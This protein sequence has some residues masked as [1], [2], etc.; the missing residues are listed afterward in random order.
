MVIV[1]LLESDS[2]SVCVCVFVFERKGM[3]RIGD[4]ELLKSFLTLCYHLMLTHLLLILLYLLCW[5]VW[6]SGI[7]GKE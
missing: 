7:G 5:I 4:C 1:G 6:T 3:E 2:V